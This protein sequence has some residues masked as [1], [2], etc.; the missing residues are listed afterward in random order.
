MPTPLSDTHPNMHALQ[1]ELLRKVTPARKLEMM[2]EL[3]A[4]VRLLALSGLRSRYPHAKERELRRRLAGLL[5]GEELAS[6][7]YGSIDDSA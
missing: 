7:V 5:L 6:K 4:S 3:N 1:I 2:A